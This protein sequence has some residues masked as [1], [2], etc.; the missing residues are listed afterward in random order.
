MGF[1]LLFQSYTNGVSPADASEIL[2]KKQ[3]DFHRRIYPARK[4]QM[5]AGSDATFKMFRISSLPVKFSHFWVFI[6][7]SLLF[8]MSIILLRCDVLPELYRGPK[9]L[10]A[11]KGPHQSPWKTLASIVCIY[12]KVCICIYI[13]LFISPWKYPRYFPIQI[14]LASIHNR[15]THTYIYKYHIPSSNQSWQWKIPQFDDLPS[16]D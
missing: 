4:D 11:K 6:Y 5:A 14:P 7:V 10:F 12:I 13:Y 9:K 3:K 8:F 1:P 2:T 15:Y 16:H